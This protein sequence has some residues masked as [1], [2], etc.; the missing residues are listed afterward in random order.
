[1]F[2]F[3]WR[4]LFPQVYDIGKKSLAMSCDLGGRVGNPVALTA[5]AGNWLVLD[6]D[7]PTISVFTT[8]VV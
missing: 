4:Q 1:M 5:S 7:G 6:A 3:L 2:S 8:L